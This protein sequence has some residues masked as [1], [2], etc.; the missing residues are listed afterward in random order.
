SNRLVVYLGDGRPSLGEL[1]ADGIRAQ[2]QRRTQGV[3]R[4]AGIALGESA[5]RWLLARLVAGSGPV[6]T[7]LDRSEAAQVAAKVVAA[8]EVTTH[9]DVRFELGTNIDR[10]Y[11]RDGRAVAAGT[12]ATVVGRLRGA[13]PTS[14][15]LSFRDEEGSKSETLRVERLGTPSEGEVARRWALARIQ[16]IV[17]GSE[18]VEPALLLA[19]QHGL[20]LPW[21][22]WVF[23]ASESKMK[24]PC[25]PFSRRIVELSTL[26]DTPYARRIEEAA[27]EGAGWLEPPTHF[28]PGQSLEQG[29]VSSGQAKIANATASILACRNARI[30]IV[31]NLPDALDYRVTLGASGNIEQLAITPHDGGRSDS[32]YLGC[33][34][35]VI[36][37]LALVGA[38]RPVT[39]SGTI[40][41]PPLRDPK[42]TQCSPIARLPLP[43]RRN[44]WATRT[45]DPLA[46]YEVALHACEATTW[47]ERRELLDGLMSQYRA[48]PPLLEFAQTLGGH[49]YL[50]A[51]DFVRSEAIR[52]VTR[53]SEL[54]ELRAQILRNEPNLD[55]DIANK[56][57]SAHADREK[58]SIVTRALAMAPHSPLGRRLQLLLLE[59]LADESGVQRL[60]ETLR[61]DPFTDA[62][63]IALTAAAVR[64]EGRVAE[65][66]RIFAE[67]FERAPRDPWVL[68]FAG[69]QLRTEGFPEQ[70][71]SAYES[72]ERV[73]PND[74]ATLLRKGL[75]QANAGRIDLAA[76]L[77]ERAAQTAGRSE[78]QR[79]NEFGGVLSS[80]VLGRAQLTTTDAA[81]KAELGRRLAQTA[82]PDV[83]AIVLVETP[84]RPEQDLTVRAYR[85]DDKTPQAP[86][87]DASTLGLTAI[88]VDRGASTITVEVA[89]RLLAGLGAAMP[90][91]L[92]ILVLGE[93]PTERQLRTLNAAIPIDQDHTH[94]TLTRELRP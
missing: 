54:V 94:I 35:R 33:I 60:I 86:D 67:L 64:R 51:A 46:R 53:L 74:T 91:T 18:G 58:L 49:G 84:A 7:V 42:R 65:G 76:R 50:D 88:F 78:D 15:K 11:P 37:S 1:T 62:G 87:L 30:H 22:A 55:A 59:R 48:A 25:S 81:E 68:A 41:L 19:R 24:V 39:V 82:L 79:L 14:V 34:E 47:T 20:L 45:G 69:D 5:D 26:N 29:A 80:V 4:I 89:R 90:I 71:L 83:A 70:A 75:A 21:T 32:V 85:G 73:T 31:P 92:S 93:S 3:P 27:P 63:L 38:E 72:L 57:K 77:L 6:H 2:L 61:S 8:A 56:V 9:R 16:E 12:T 36:R 43:L 44:V 40:N 10:I 28:D 66:Q 17:A 13:L 52:R 23:P